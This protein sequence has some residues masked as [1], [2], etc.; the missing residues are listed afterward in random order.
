MLRRGRSAT[1]RGRGSGS[2]IN[3]NQPAIVAM[4]TQDQTPPINVAN[5]NVGQTPAAIDNNTQ[6]VNVLNAPAQDGAGP[7][8][9]QQHQQG[10]QEQGI[11]PAQN[12]IPAAIAQ[13][14]EQPPAWVA[15]FLAAITAAHQQS[16]DAR[17][18][19]LEARLA[20]QSQHSVNKLDE[21][22]LRQLSSIDNF[23]GTG[24]RPWEDFEQEFRN[25]ASQ[26]PSLPR[27]EWVRYLHFQVKD[28][29]LEYAKV[30]GLV[31]SDNAL[32]CTDFEEYC[33]K[34]SEAMFGDS[35]SKT[36]KI[37]TLATMT[38]TGKLTNPVDFLRA[39]EKILNQIPTEDMAGYIRAALTTLGMDPAL[40]AAISP[41]PSSADGLYHSYADVRKQV[42]AVL[43]INQQLFNAAAQNLQNSQKSGWQQKSHKGNSNQSSATDKQSAQ[44]SGQK[45]SGNFSNSQQPK[46]T[47]NQPSGDKP[48]VAA[49]STGSDKPVHKKPNPYENT[50]C[51]DCGKKGHKNK[52]Y[53]KCEKHNT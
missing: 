51:E 19:A 29:A 15:Q 36:A 45:R 11:V 31:S 33:S 44:P 37:H 14:A 53:F 32:L 48:A 42:V 41:N 7:S 30:Q 49:G 9:V 8:G 13:N 35:L 24:T 26:I 20:Q 27:T 2:G 43:G 23:T 50:I 28:R 12:L 10:T 21:T 22:L 3:D 6:Q 16:T 38:Q 39:K 34:M 47:S 46:S 25:K 40:V 4:A 17:I 52:G 1:N 18:A 5:A